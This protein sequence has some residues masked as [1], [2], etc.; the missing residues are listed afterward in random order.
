M[1][2]SIHFDK[3]LILEMKSIDVQR[4]LLQ[5]PYRWW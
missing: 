1:V 2:D 5:D 3:S 4:G